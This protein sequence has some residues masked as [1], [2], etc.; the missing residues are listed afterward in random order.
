MTEHEPKEEQ[1]WEHGGTTCEVRPCLTRPG[2]EAARRHNMSHCPRAG[3]NCWSRQKAKSDHHHKEALEVK[4]RDLARV[5][6]DFMY[7]GAEGTFV[8]ERAK[9]T[10][11]MV[12]CKDDGNLAATVMRTKTDHY[13]VEMVLL[14][15]TMEIWRL[16]DGKPITLEIDGYNLDGTRMGRCRWNNAHVIS[17]CRIA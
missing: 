1:Q 3:A 17:T 6:M 14:F 11:L 13:G 12:V 10:F 15:L 16:T 7:V 4:D 8:D 2:A 9:A 5:Q